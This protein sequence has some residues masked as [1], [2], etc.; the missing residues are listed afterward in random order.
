M[1]VQIWIAI[2]TYLTIAI[3]KKELK[4]ERSLYEILQILSLSTFDKMP[5]NQLVISA[6]LQNLEDESHNQLTFNFL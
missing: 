6:E 4:I 5:V 2:C 3:A 1:K